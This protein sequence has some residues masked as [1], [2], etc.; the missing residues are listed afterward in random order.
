M[1]KYTTK[2]KRKSSRKANIAHNKYKRIVIGI[3]VLSAIIA[4]VILISEYKRVFGEF[5]SFSEAGFEKKYPVRGVDISHH[6]EYINWL[7]LVEDGISFVFM[8]STE[9][10]DHT[11]REYEYNYHLAKEV[12]LK[13]GAY[14]FYTFGVDGREQAMHFINNSIVEYGD[15]IPA[16]DV[17]H[18]KVNQPVKTDEACDKIIEELKKME[19]VISEFYGVRPIIYTNK[20]CF[21]LYIEDNF[22]NNPL[23]ICDLHDEPSEAHG[24]WDIWQFSHVGSLRGAI[25]N[26]DLNFYRGSFEEFKSLLLPSHYEY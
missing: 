20:D 7:M 23:W 8:K 2:R 16:I 11:D 15:I 3:S 26:I 12:G 22:P 10:I 13:V 19:E 18:S 6:N 14:H 17:E 4:I 9:G 24:Q 21:K 25:G 5:D 1:E